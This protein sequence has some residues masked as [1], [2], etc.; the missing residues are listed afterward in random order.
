M[1]T[2]L[3]DIGFYTL[4]DQRAKKANSKTPLWR[5]ELLLTDKCNFRCSYCRGPKTG[6]EGSLALEEAKSVIDIWATENVQN[7]RFSGGEPIYW[8]GL[9]DLIKYTAQ[10]GTKRIA[11]STNGSGDLETYLA[12]HRAGVTDFSISLDA[13]C[14]KVGD[15]MSGGI[16][17]VW[18]KL[19]NNIR[20][21]S[22][23]TYVTVGVVLLEENINQFNRIIEF[24]SDDLGVADIRVISAAQWNEKLPDKVL[25]RKDILDRNPILNYRIDN[26]KRGRH[27]RGI[28]SR[29]F[30]KCPLVLDD[31]AVLEGHH[32]P[33]IIYLREHGAPI[34][35]LDKNV[36]AD[37][38]TWFKEHDTY[39]DPICRNNCLDVCVDYN[40][41][42]RETN[43]LNRV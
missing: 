5:C 25:I 9:E 2:S 17:G 14:A 19:T 35:K 42:W 8:K 36:R 7:V 1:T 22:R 29:D 43:A 23:L 31:M 12:I 30:N 21:L 20:A 13:C 34:G 16:K 32:F 15:A 41:K 24:A 11:I 3:N 38:E 26:L 33:C 40:N 18:E 39:E 10:R 37:R 27:V 4:T 28:K 6:Y